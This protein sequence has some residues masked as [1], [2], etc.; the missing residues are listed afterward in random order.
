MALGSVIVVLSTVIEVG[1]I[2][3]KGTQ[4]VPVFFFWII[5]VFLELI[6]V[7]HFFA[8]FF[9]FVNTLQYIL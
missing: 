8:R 5:R 4:Y 3:Q 1:F 2:G 6:M 7:I 9:I